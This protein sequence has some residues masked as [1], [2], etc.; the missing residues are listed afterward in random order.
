MSLAVVCAA[1][2]SFLVQP[3]GGG[4]GHSIPTSKD[5]TKLNTYNI[6]Y[7]TAYL[8]L[9]CEY[10]ESPSWNNANISI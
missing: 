7:K 2:R 6:K 4:G 10:C 3:Q 1:R 8:K 5:H 9:S